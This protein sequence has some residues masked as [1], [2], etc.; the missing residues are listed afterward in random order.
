MAVFDPDHGC[1]FRSRLTPNYSSSGLGCNCGPAHTRAPEK[2][3][4]ERYPEGKRTLGQPAPVCCATGAASRPIARLGADRRAE[5][6]VADSHVRPKRRS[7]RR[8]TERRPELVGSA[9]QVHSGAAGRSATG[10]SGREMLD[11]SISVDDPLRTSGHASSCVAWP[12]QPSVL[13]R[14]RLS[15]GLAYGYRWQ[16]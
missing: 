12:T 16:P 3:L 6:W 9:L 5:R 14:R 10:E 4:S 1:G 7:W 11:P 13:T 2:A 15:V 8:G